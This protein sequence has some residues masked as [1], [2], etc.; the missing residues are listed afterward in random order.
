MVL[1]T[2]F[3]MLQAIVIEDTVIYPLTGSAFTVNIFVLL[4]IPQYTGLEAQ[5]AVVLY[6]NGAAIAARGTSSSMR[7]FFNAAAFQWAAVFMGSFDR[8]I[9]PWTHFMACPAKR[10]ALFVESNVIRGIFGSFC[11][12]VDVD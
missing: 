1:S 12:A 8:I 2:Y 6:V 7:A 9:S 3:Q 10:M 11:P 4:G 5:V